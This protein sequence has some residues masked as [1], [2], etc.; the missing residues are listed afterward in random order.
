MLALS[1]IASFYPDHMKRYPRFMLR[2]YLQHKILEI[3]FRSRHSKGALFHGGSCL[4]II[5]K[6]HRFSENL[7]FYLTGLEEHRSERNGIADEI[8]KEL[9]L[10]GFPV[11]MKRLKKGELICTIG[12]PE[13]FFE[14]MAIDG[15][16]NDSWIQDN[17]ACESNDSRK[18]IKRKHDNTKFR[19]HVEHI[20]IRFREDCASVDSD[21]SPRRDLLNRFD[22][23][24]TVLSIS[25]P[26]QLSQ[27]F[28]I[29]LTQDQDQ[30][31]DQDQVQDQVRGRDF[32]DAI[33]LMSF[34][35]KPNYHYL[36]SKLS[37]SGPTELKNALLQSTLS[38]N[39]K[40]MIADIT[41]YLTDIT[42]ADKVLAFE[43]IVENYFI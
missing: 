28:A 35:V 17:R 36:E 39:M 23:F 3:V 11:E 27:K 7:D 19:G 15:L 42:L 29:I 41:P 38:L 9:R 20:R 37:I 13:L 34:Q 25:L 10:Q 14:K 8:K 31:Q 32:I 18:Q 30:M 43:E 40:D 22:V 21:L 5:H 33:I 26:L 1:D 16:A 12:F 2:E 6:S 4:R 24:T